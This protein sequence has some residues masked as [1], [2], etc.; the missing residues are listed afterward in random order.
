MTWIFDAHAAAMAA[1]VAPGSVLIDL[2]A[3][4]CAKAARLFSALRPAGYVAI[5]ISVDY[6][7]EAL[8]D[9][10]ARHPAMPMLGLG[11]DFSAAQVQLQ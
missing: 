2:G 11:L 10:Q 5:D 4:S 9:L 3:G 8:G 7:R 1:C 6:L